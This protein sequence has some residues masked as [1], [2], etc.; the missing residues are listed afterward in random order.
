M[1]SLCRDLWSPLPE[2]LLSNPISLSAWK[3]YPIPFV[4]LLGCSRKSRICLSGL[5]KIFDEKKIQIS[6]FLSLLI[7]QFLKI[8]LSSIWQRYF[9]FGNPCATYVCRKYI[10]LKI[11]IRHQSRNYYSKKYYFIIQT[12]NFEATMLLFLDEIRNLSD[13]FYLFN[14]P[15]QFNLFHLIQVTTFS[16]N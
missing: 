13:V 15:P 9:L 12:K 1:K 4:S 10:L 14:F 11:G 3:L 16:K 7:H 2:I 5:T 6:D 8:H